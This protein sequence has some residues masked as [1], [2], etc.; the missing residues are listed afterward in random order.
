MR[1]NYSPRDKIAQFHRVLRATIFLS[2]F[3]FS[4]TASELECRG[5]D[6]SGVTACWTKSSS[7]ALS[8]FPINLVDLPNAVI[9]GITHR[10]RNNSVSHYRVSL[11][12][13]DLS[14]SWLN[15]QVADTAFSPETTRHV[16]DMESQKRLVARS[17]GRSRFDRLIRIRD[18]SRTGW[19]GVYKPSP[20]APWCYAVVLALEPSPL[21]ADYADDLY[22]M[23]LRMKDCTGNRTRVQLEDWLH[24]VRAVPDGYNGK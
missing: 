13:G 4:S 23:V 1:S 22:E 12:P 21:S 19:L 24:T 16:E 3:A 14:S 17:V 15:L 20:K 18:H 10:L 11:D 7:A 6:V 2:V 8:S 5:K 9:G